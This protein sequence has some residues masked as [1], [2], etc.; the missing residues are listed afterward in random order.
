MVRASQLFA[1][2]LTARGS[3]GLKRALEAFTDVLRIELAGS[4]GEKPL[5]LSGQALIDAD[6]KS[7][8]S[9]R[10]TMGAPFGSAASRMAD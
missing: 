2:H 1:R 3:G 8:P 7:P 10:A 5:K 6:G 9:Y 4:G